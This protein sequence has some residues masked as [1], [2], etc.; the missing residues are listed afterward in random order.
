MQT[1]LRGDELRGV[2]P[3]G[4]CGDG[5]AGAGDEFGGGADQCQCHRVCHVMSVPP[6]DACV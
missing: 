4:V 3:A 6:I 2:G 5:S 1:Q